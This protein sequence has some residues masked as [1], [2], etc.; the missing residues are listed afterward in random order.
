MSTK[1][2]RVK[3]PGT[4]H[5]VTVPR[6]FAEGHKLEI[7]D[8]EA[9][10]DNGRP[11]PGKPHVELEKAQSDVA[12]SGTPETD[13]ATSS[14]TTDQTPSTENVSAPVAG[15]DTASGSGPKAGKAATR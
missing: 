14:T 13:P 11:L 1:F 8:K 3:D 7:L 10:D 12:G 4:G 9:V 2:V 15:T 5:E 6:P